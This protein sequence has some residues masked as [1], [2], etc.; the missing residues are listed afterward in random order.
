[1]RIAVI[2]LIITWIV[3]FIHSWSTLCFRA[4]QGILLI[5]GSAARALLGADVT[6]TVTQGDANV[7]LVNRQEEE[8]Y[9]ML[10][11]RR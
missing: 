8:D 4:F 1:M 7:H 6:G 9:A 5:M 10:H 11:A 2:L 3:L